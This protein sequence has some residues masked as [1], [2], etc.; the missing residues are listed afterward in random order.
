MGHTRTTREQKQAWLRD[1][2]V[3]SSE[4]VLAVPKYTERHYSPKEIAE[5]WCLSEDKVRE[6]FRH[7]SGVLVIGGEGGRGKRGYAVLRIPESV[8]ERVHR[9]LSNN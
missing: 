8:L 3:P 9:M 6:M 5:M 2:N 4:S 1:R 7:E